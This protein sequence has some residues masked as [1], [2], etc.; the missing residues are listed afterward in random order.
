MNL[1]IR[2]F[3]NFCYS[4]LE[5]RAVTVMELLSG[6]SPS[7]GLSPDERRRAENLVLAFRQGNKQKAHQLSAEFNTQVL[8][9]GICTSAYFL[10][11][12]QH[13]AG[14]SEYLIVM[15][16]LKESYGQQ[17]PAQLQALTLDEALVILLL[18]ITRS[19]RNSIS[20]TRLDEKTGK[21]RPTTFPLTECMIRD[22][23]APFG[24]KTGL[25]KRFLV[26]SK[27]MVMGNPA[28]WIAQGYRLRKQS[29][30]LELAAWEQEQ[31]TLTRPAPQAVGQIQEVRILCEDLRKLL[32]GS[33]DPGEK[34][35]LLHSLQPDQLLKMV[36]QKENAQTNSQEYARDFRQ[37][38]ESIYAARLSRS[39][40]SYLSAR[41][42]SR[43]KRMLDQMGDWKDNY[44]SEFQN[45]MQSQGIW[46]GGEWLEKWR[47]GKTGKQH[48]ARQGKDYLIQETSPTLEDML[49]QAEKIQDKLKGGQMLKPDP[50]SWKRPAVRP[51]PEQ[52]KL[53]TILSRTDRLEELVALAFPGEVWGS[54]APALRRKLFQGFCLLGDTDFDA[55]KSHFLAAAEPAE[56]EAA[57][58]LITTLELKFNQIV[59]LFRQDLGMT[60]SHALAIL[61]ARQEETAQREKLNSQSW[62]NSPAGHYARYQQA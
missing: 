39:Q 25:M 34:S 43:M 46:E 41:L 17:R 29:Y 18:A 2:P 54:Y 61:V 56:Q 31:A 11:L 49:D 59:G 35:A 58:A 37:M 1:H 22:F 4:A 6:R 53:L 5:A 47:A 10:L 62:Q 26:F 27:A 60:F 33:H 28:A 48:L 30:E 8:Q 21:P 3:P 51:S 55:I 57:K 13:K 7:L 23:L 19:D 12:D 32:E 15:D 38:L 20:Y 50:S 14:N 24:D 36:R 45:L 44:W 52:S 9:A 40:A 16:S 42:S